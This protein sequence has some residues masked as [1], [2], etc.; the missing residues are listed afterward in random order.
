MKKND[1]TDIES[2]VV[3]PAQFR[4]HYINEKVH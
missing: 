1:K 2:R 3:I 4:Y